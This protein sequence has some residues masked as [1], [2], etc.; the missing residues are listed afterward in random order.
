[1][2]VPFPDPST[3]KLLVGSTKNRLLKPLISQVETRPRMSWVSW[4]TVEGRRTYGD[5]YSMSGGGFH[6]LGEHLP[7]EIRSQRR[8]QSDTGWVDGNTRTSRET[9]S[10]LAQR[11][12][13]YRKGEGRNGEKPNKPGETT[14]SSKERIVSQDLHLPSF[15]CPRHRTDIT[16]STDVVG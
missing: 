7:Y 3:P 15:H 16:H 9:M 14:H 2:R 11:T 6:R 5:P 12:L 1:M 13:D 8:L 10:C 4:C